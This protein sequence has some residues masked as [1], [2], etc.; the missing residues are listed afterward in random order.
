MPLTDGAV[1]VPGVGHIFTNT[2]LGSKWTPAQLATY[3]SA[4]TVPTGWHEVGHTDLNTILT[5][6]QTGGT[7]TTKGS[8]QNPS[9]RTIT[10]DV[11][12][13]FEVNAEQVLDDDVLKMYHGG[14]DDTTTAG[15]F[16]WPDAPAPLERAVYL[17]MLDGST[18]LGLAI[19]KAS[20]FRSNAPAFASDDF[21]KLPLSFTILQYTG[22]KRAYWQNAA[23][24]S[25]V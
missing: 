22:M 6:T 5:F 9:L 4:G 12:D 13:S 10:S 17:A 23:L 8:W 18:P 21:M 15:E 3:A 19:P 14:G 7:T 20:I 1:L 24:G 2:T 11:V 16:A 25:G